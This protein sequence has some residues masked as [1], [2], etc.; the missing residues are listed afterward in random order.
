MKKEQQ[1]WHFKEA[2]WANAGVQIG[3]SACCAIGTEAGRIRKVPTGK[4]AS[5]VFA[6]SASDETIHTLANPNPDS[7]AALPKLCAVP[8]QWRTF[9]TKCLLV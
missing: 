8:V 9:T 1:G 4:V 2:S 3:R 5:V 6:K 7:F